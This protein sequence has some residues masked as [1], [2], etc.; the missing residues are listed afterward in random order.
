[1][2][3]HAFSMIRNVATIHPRHAR[4]TPAVLTAARFNGHPSGTFIHETT[5]DYSNNIMNI[6]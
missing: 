5:S 1:M 6:E 2:S 4:Y 3:R